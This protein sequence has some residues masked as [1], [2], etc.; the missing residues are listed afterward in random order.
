MTIRSFAAG[1]ALGAAFVA[2]PAYAQSTEAL[3]IAGSS[4]VLPY[5]QIVA[6]TFG[7]TYPDFPTPVVESGGSGAGLKQFCA[8][9]G[10]STIDI[11]NSSRAI[12]DS[13]K[14]T[15]K[16]NGVSDIQEVKFGYDGIVFA[17]DAAGPDF[18]L[19]PA[20]VF[21]ALAA[22]TVVDGKVVDNAAKTWADV[23]ASL[24]AWKIETYIPGEKHGTRE[25]FEEKLLAAGCKETGALEAFKA[26]GLDEKAA[27]EQC[28]AVRK[29]GG[30]VDIDGDYNETLARIDSN[31]QGVGVFGLAFFEQN[32]DKLKVAT[33]NDVVPTVETI[34]KGE[35]PVSRPLYFYVKKAHIGVVPGLKEYV[36]FFLS[37]DMIGP[38]SPLAQYGLVPA[39]DAEREAYR[40]DFDA[41]KTM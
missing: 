13:E 12:K 21:K 38:E 32:Q 36:D 6:E 4:T 20:L 35:Y 15:C 29:D 17:S 27:A 11:A 16:S 9:V 1:L 31:K 3:Q 14:E 24:P 26:S 28:H 7:E 40:S 25:V 8:G 33:V 30:A 41:G 5:A 39:P 18:K 2:A 37:E 19:T 23:D 34:S 22:K 10:S